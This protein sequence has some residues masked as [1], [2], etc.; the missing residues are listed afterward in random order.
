MASSRKYPD[1]KNTIQIIT[2][3]LILGKEKRRLLESHGWYRN[4]TG[5]WTHPHCLDFMSWVEIRSLTPEQLSYKLHYGSRSTLPI[6]LAK[7]DK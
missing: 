1:F 4:M 7:L 5:G 2:E 3:Y 6:R